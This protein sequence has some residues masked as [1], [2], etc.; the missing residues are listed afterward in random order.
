MRIISRCSVATYVL[1][2]RL[3]SRARHI[4]DICLRTGFFFGFYTPLMF[5]CTA[6]YVS[7]LTHVM[8]ICSIGFNQDPSGI[9]TPRTAYSYAF[10]VPLSSTCFICIYVYI[11][12]CRYIFPSVVPWSCGFPLIFTIPFMKN[13]LY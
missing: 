8:I 2:L 6:V 1:L 4:I 3:T 13:F 11:S 10:V 9:D 5:H 7:L 12:C